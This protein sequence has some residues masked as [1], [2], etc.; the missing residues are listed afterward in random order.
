MTSHIT[1]NSNVL[2][3]I[4]QANNKGNIN[5]QHYQPFVRATKQQSPVNAPPN[6]PVTGEL[7][8]WRYN[9]GGYVLINPLHPSS[10][11]LR[12]VV[13]E[14]AMSPPR[15]NLMVPIQEVNQ[16]A[17]FDPGIPLI[18]SNITGYWIYVNFS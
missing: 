4:V 18:S 12:A 2:S 9:Y 10:N 11:S 16:L 8:L 3:Q 5:A 7:L 15:P 13:Y 6:R 1:G 17:V 14:F